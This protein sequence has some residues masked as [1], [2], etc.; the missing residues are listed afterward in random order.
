MRATSWTLF[1]SALSFVAL[2]ACG[3][4]DTGFPTIFCSADP[5]VCPDGWT[6]DEGVCRPPAVGVGSDA[7]GADAGADAGGADTGGA[8]AGT[9]VTS[10]VVSD[11][12]ADADAGETPGFSALGIVSITAA[13]NDIET[14]TPGPDIDAIQII[15]DGEPVYAAA[16]LGSSV[17]LVGAEGN[18]ND[19]EN[20]I[21]GPNDAIPSPDGSLDCDLTE[22]DEGGAFFSLGGEG[23]YLMVSFVFSLEPGDEIRVFELDQSTCANVSTVREDAYAVYLGSVELAGFVGEADDIDEEDGW[24]AIGVSSGGLF[25]AVVPE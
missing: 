2:A 11:A 12:G 18:D 14:D 17:G 1:V 23:G 6:C 8:D 19:D 22:A 20:A 21:L 25:D 4:D 10:D 9:D 13:G 7:S 24:T 16:I 15:R 5:S 3:D